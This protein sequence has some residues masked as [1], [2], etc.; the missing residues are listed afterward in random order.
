MSLADT[1]TGSARPLYPVGQPV[2]IEN[3]QI[4]REGEGE[5]EHVFG[6]R[7]LTEKVAA[8]V[9]IIVYSRVPFRYK[10][11]AVPYK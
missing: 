3:S 5:G 4:T 10:Y 2:A 6:R 9:V 8:I 11:A 1:A 7:T